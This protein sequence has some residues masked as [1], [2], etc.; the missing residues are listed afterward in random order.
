MNVEG[1]FSWKTVL[2]DRSPPLLVSLC[3][4]HSPLFIIYSCGVVLVLVFCILYLAGLA[5][6]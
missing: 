1:I 2:V 5:H 3:T 6:F 4:I